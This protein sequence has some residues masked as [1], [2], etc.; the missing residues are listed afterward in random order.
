MIIRVM[1]LMLLRFLISAGADAE[2]PCHGRSYGDDDFED[3]APTA[4]ATAMMTL[5]TMPHTVL[6]VLFFCCIKIGR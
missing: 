4:E 1:C 3:D 5:R 2:C 6:G